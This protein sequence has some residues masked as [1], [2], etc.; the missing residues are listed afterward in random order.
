MEV[1]IKTDLLNQQIDAI[2]WLYLSL[3][4]ITLILNYLAMNAY[5][6]WNNLNCACYTAMSK[7]YKI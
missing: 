3:Q 2:S 5:S 4:S 1:S 7:N 6:T